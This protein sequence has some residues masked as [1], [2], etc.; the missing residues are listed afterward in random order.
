MCPISINLPSVYAAP[1]GAPVCA[2]IARVWVTVLALMLMANVVSMCAVCVTFGS[3]A[4]PL[5]KLIKYQINVHQL[6][7]ASA[8][9]CAIIIS[10]L[11][12]WLA[13]SR[14]IHQLHPTADRP[15][16]CHFLPRVQLDC[17]DKATRAGIGRLRSSTARSRRAAPIGCLWA[18][19]HAGEP[20]VN[21][22]ITSS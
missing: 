7:P 4:P 9:P 21:E 2:L 20:F 13:G 3:P 14:P 12:G 17:A 16:D 19:N 6:P 22:I 8:T 11:S 18:D 5:H 15:A 10:D 1:R